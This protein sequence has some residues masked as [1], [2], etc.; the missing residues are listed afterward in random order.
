MEP[1]FVTKPAFTAV[2]MLY[3]GKNENHEIAQMWQVFNP[4]IREIQHISDGAF[5]LC[6]PPDES[7]EFSYLASMGVS[8]ASDVP[9]GM[10]IW[11]VPEQHYTVFTCTLPTL[12]ETYR[13][14]FENWLPQSGYEYS[15]GADF[16]YYDEDFDP[17]SPDGVMYVYI[18]VRK[19]AG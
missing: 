9:A 17:E 3:H 12:G 6:L 8:D 2:G 13:Y 10:E 15:E 14:V 19:K 5:G 18:P 1:R 11:Q 16:E 7:G 4:R